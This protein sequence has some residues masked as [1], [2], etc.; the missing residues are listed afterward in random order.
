MPWMSDIIQIDDTIVG[1]AVWQEHGVR[2]IAIDWR[3][4]ELD[5]TRWDT[6]D[7]ARRAADQLIRTG[8]VE[9][10]TPPAIQE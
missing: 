10:F 3:V 9:N 1:A 2:F 6:A 4:G 7:A 8:K 5:Q